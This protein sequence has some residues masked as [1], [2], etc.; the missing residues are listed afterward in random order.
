MAFFDQNFSGQGRAIGQLNGEL[1]VWEL[2]WKIERI[3]ANLSQINRHERNVFPISEANHFAGKQ[4]HSLV[5]RRI[6]NVV[7][8]QLSVAKEPTPSY[9]TF[10]TMKLWIIKTTPTDIR[11]LPSHMGGLTVFR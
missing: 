7:S 10:L 6:F 3:F 8:L 9:S 5:A 11:H 2:V 1:G 4:G